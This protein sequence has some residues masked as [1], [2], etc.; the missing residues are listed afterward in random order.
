MSDPQSP[1]TLYIANT[2]RVAAVV[3]VGAIASNTIVAFAFSRLRWWGRDFWF[4]VM[5]STMMLPTQ[6]TI[7]PTY[8]LFNL[9]GWIDTCKPL[10]VPSFFAAAWTGFLLRQVMVTI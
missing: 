3:M 2:L 6:V 4:M 1:F 8:I 10:I 9:L 7:I 5:L